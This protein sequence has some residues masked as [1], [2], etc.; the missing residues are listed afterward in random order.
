MKMTKGFS[1]IEVMVVVAIIALLSAFAI[2][3]YMRSRCKADW[4]ELQSCLSD[5][6]LR[7]E[8][9]RS[10]HGLYPPQ[11]TALADIGLAA[12]YNCGRHYKGS[13]EIGN[14]QTS[15]KV[16]VNDTKEKLWCSKNPGDDEWVVINSSTKVYHTKNSVDG[17]TEPLP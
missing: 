1:L 8:N 9:Y 13:I 11:S 6:S 16:I 7:L 2:P 3:S 12:D 5:M 14:S 17:K 15:Y 10:N 4:G